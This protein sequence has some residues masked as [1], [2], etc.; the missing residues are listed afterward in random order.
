MANAPC[1]GMLSIDG[2]VVVVAGI[3]TVVCVAG[4]DTVVAVAG[5]DTVVVVA[6]IDTV[7]AVAGILLSSLMRCLVPMAVCSTL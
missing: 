2:V 6:G 5:I 7:V 1:N 3:D 4:I